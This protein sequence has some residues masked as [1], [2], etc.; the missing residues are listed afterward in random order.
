VEL[1][2]EW[3]TALGVAIF[4]G[5]LP[6]TSRA[7]DARLAFTHKLSTTEIIELKGAPLVCLLGTI[8]AIANA[9]AASTTVISVG[10]TG[11]T[12][13]RKIRT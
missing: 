2:G 6:R 11:T 8:S 1:S 12:I 4:Y 10:C 5:R 7:N 3:A 9:L 13:E